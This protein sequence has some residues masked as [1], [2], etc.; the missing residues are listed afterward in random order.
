MII[1]CI[2]CNK[3]FNVNA[4]LIPDD[5]RTIQCGS[6][7]HVWFFKKSDISNQEIISKKTIDIPEISRKK[8]QTKK[9]PLNPNIKKADSL[10]PKV[11]KNID[12]KS[13]EIVEYK[14]KSNFTFTKFLSYTLVL[15]ISLVALLI[16]L[17]TFKILLYRFFPELEFLL[18]S[19]FETLKD[20]KLFIKDLI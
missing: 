4:E 2:N 1:E 16:F 17:D 20:I 7:N 10:K 11:P 13:F 19:L 5:G 8:P 9:K 18:F 14:S 3:K 15:I 6:C 12:D